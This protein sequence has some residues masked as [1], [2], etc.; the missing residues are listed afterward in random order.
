MGE[1]VGHA[2]TGAGG[3][4]ALVDLGDGRVGSAGALDPESSQAT[5]AVIRK[6]RKAVT[7]L[8]GDRTASELSEAVGTETAQFVEELRQAGDHDN[9][10]TRVRPALLKSDP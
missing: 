6:L 10:N 1:A 9:W 3:V 2:V 8:A 7:E 5:V 4:A